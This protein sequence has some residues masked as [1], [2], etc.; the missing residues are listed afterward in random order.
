MNNKPNENIL[1]NM[2]EIELLRAENVEL[3]MK[4]SYYNH[5]DYFYETFTKNQQSLVDLKNE[6]NRLKK[7]LELLNQRISALEH[8]NTVFKIDTDILKRDNGILKRDNG[9]LKRDN[10][11]LK[12][13]NQKLNAKLDSLITA[14]EVKRIL[15]AMQDTNRALGIKQAMINK[16]ESNEILDGLIDMEDDRL[17]IAHFIDDRDNPDVKNCKILS[18]RNRI[19][20]AN[21]DVLQMLREQYGNLIDVFFNYVTID[22][23][24]RINERQQKKI[25]KYWTM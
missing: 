23:T 13:D 18:L 22:E 5:D 4:L 11:I 14:A 15:I 8:D 1:N 19:K 21:D 6:N 7:E 20:H 25:D 3:K 10:G 2:S 9:I 12:R 16:H 24:R 17:F